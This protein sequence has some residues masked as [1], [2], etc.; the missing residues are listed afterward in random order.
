M[1]TI[2]Y[3][4]E[5]QDLYAILISPFLDIK[6]YKK[7][8]FSKQ[9]HVL[10]YFCISRSDEKLLDLYNFSQNNNQW[11][12]LLVRS[13]DQHSNTLWFRSLVQK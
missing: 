8:I 13:S 7:H 12:Q 5:A 10:T 3:V 1:D 4:K 11:S 6:H 2:Q 9:L